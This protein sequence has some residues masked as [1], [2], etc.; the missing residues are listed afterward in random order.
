MQHPNFTEA[1]VMARVELY[2][3]FVDEL[4]DYYTW[5]QHINADQDPLTV[6]ECLE[7]ILVNPLP[8]PV[9]LGDLEMEQLSVDKVTV[10]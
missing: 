2:N 5:G 1:K 10:S 9:P 4:V 6:F 3:G 7:S 8:K